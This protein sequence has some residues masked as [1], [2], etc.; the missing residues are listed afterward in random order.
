MSNSQSPILGRLSKK[1]GQ[2]TDMELGYGQSALLNQALYLIR[3][4]TT[5]SHVTLDL[6]VDLWRFSIMAISVWLCPAFISR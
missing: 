2:F 1:G 3:A 6:A 5:E 4:I